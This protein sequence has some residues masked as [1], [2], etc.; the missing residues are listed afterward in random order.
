MGSNSVFTFIWI[1]HNFAKY[2]HFM[3]MAFPFRYA[4]LHLREETLSTV[5]HRHRIQNS[6]NTLIYHTVRLISAGLLLIAAPSPNVWLQ[7]KIIN[8]MPQQN[9][10]AN[11]YIPPNLQ[12]SC[13]IPIWRISIRIWN[14]SARRLISFT[15]VYSGVGGVVKNSFG[16]VSLILHVI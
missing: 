7:V 16:P 1:P 12:A 2:L 8:H 6:G 14:M 4:G 15:K 10:L 9:S 5:R 11:T 3:M 13:L